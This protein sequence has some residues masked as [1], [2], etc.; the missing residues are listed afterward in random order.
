MFYKESTGKKRSTK[1]KWISV[2]EQSECKND[3][4]MCFISSK[5]SIS[6]SIK[7]T[8]KKCQTL[9]RFVHNAHVLIICTNFLTISNEKK[10]KNRMA[11]AIRILLKSKKKASRLHCCCTYIGNA[12]PDLTSTRRRR[13]KKKKHDSGIKMLNCSGTYFQVCALSFFVKYKNWSMRLRSLTLWLILCVPR[14][15]KTYNWNIFYFLACMCALQICW[16]AICNELWYISCFTWPRVS[17]LFILFIFLFSTF[18]L[19]V[20]VFFHLFFVLSLFFV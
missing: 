7:R 13:M 15:F 8:Q 1:I 11:L 17:A 18:L 2:R 12:C 14:L 4:R 10:G 5:H 19:C 16:S 9:L 20:R 3:K 6:P